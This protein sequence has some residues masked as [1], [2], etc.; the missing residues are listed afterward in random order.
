LL[1]APTVPLDCCVAA[2]AVATA[3]A[4]TATVVKILAALSAF[5]LLILLWTLQ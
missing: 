5:F 1:T 4:A 2:T 3:T